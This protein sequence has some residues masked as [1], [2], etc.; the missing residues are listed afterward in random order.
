MK[1]TQSTQQT[2][3]RI[4]LNKV[5][6]SGRQPEGLNECKRKRNK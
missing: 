2:I 1:N 3:D 6:T 5:F 4:K